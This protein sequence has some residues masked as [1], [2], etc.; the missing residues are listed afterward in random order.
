MNKIG[1]RVLSLFMSAIMLLSLLPASALAAQADDRGERLDTAGIYDWL[2]ENY[3][4]AEE[5]GSI[6]Y[7]AGALAYLLDMMPD[8]PGN[9]GRSIAAFT[10][11]DEERDAEAFR[12]DAEELEAAAYAAEPLLALYADGS[13]YLVA[14]TAEDDAFFDEELPAEEPTEESSE[15]PTEE[16]FEEPA[17]EPSEEP[18]E[19]PTEEPFEEPSEGDWESDLL[20]NAA[21]Q[22]PV[23]L[24]ALYKGG[25]SGNLGGQEGGIGTLDLFDD[26]TVTFVFLDAEGNPIAIES[27][28][29]TVQDAEYILKAGET[30]SYPAAPV[31][32]T[33]AEGHH[34]FT[35]W[36]VN[37]ADFPEDNR[38]TTAFAKAHDGE[39]I[40]VTPEYHSYWLVSFK[41]YETEEICYTAEVPVNGTLTSAQ[42]AEAD[43]AFAKTRPGWKPVW[44]DSFDPK[45]PVT[46]DLTVIAENSIEGVWVSFDS[47]DGTFV[48]QKQPD[49][50]GTLDLTGSETRPT[51]KGYTFAGWYRDEAAETDPVGDTLTGVTTSVT[52]YAK[53]TPVETTYTVIYWMENANWDNATESKRD[54]QQ[55]SSFG[56]E[57]REGLTGQPATYDTRNL[58]NGGLGDQDGA[59]FTTNPRVEGGK[60][61]SGDGTTIVNVFYDRLS[62]SMY[63]HGS[64]SNGTLTCGQEEHT[65]TY[66]RRTGEWWYGYTYYGGCY[67]RTGG[68]SPMCGQ[69]EHTH[70][71]NCYAAHVLTAKYGA[72]I[73]EQWPKNSFGTTQW[74]NADNSYSSTSRTFM[75]VMPL[76][77]QFDGDDGH[78]YEPSRGSRTQTR[79]FYVEALPGDSVD[80]TDQDGVKY[81]EYRRVETYSNFGSIATWV[82]LEGCDFKT[83]DTGSWSSHNH[84]VRGYYLRK[85]F[86]VQ[87]QMPGY[88]EQNSTVSVK[89]GAPI[90]GPE[91]YTPELA[92]KTFD[93]WYLSEAFKTSAADTLNGHMPSKSITV[94]GRWKTETCDVTVRE[95]DK[96]DQF[97]VTVNSKT[98]MTMEQLIAA[99]KAANPGFDTENI[100]AFYEGNALVNFPTTFD[101]NV[102]LTVGRK[103]QTKPLSY[104]EN[105]GAATPDT[106][107]KYPL[108][109][110]AP[111]R[112]PAQATNDAG[113][114]FDYWTSNLSG[115]TTKY[116]P[117][118]MILVTPNTVLTAHYA[119]V[120]VSMVKVTYHPNFTGTG[121]A[122]ITS[123]LVVNNKK[124]TIP[125]APKGWV[126]AQTASGYAFKGWATS[127]T[128]AAADPNYAP[129][130]L[131]GVDD[132]TAIPNELWAVWSPIEYTITYNLVGGARETGVTYVEKYTV[133]TPSFTGNYS[134]VKEHF[135]FTGWTTPADQ[136]NVVYT[137]PTKSIE[138]PQGTTGNLTF[139]ANWETTKYPYTVEYYY[140][141]NGNS[142]SATKFGAPTGAPTGDPVGLPYGTTG[143]TA[144]IA[145]PYN[146]VLIGD[147]HYAYDSATT[148]T[149]SDVAESNVVRVYYA[150]DEKGGTPENPGDGIPDKY[151]ITVNYVA[152]DNGTIVGGNKTETITITS[153]TSTHP[154][155]WATSGNVTT[156][157]RAQAQA[158]STFKFTNWTVPA[159][160][161]LAGSVST[162]NPIPETRLT[163]VTGD[164]TYIFTANFE[165][166][167]YT[168]IYEANQGTW[169][170]GTKLVGGNY[171]ETVNAG[172]NVVTGTATGAISR[173]GFDLVGWTYTVNGKEVVYTSNTKTP[174]RIATETGNTTSNTITLTA[175]WV[176]QTPS[177]TII[178]HFR[179][180]KLGEVGTTSTATNNDTFVYGTPLAQ[181]I[182]NADKADQTYPAADGKTYIYDSTADAYRIGTTGNILALTNQTLTADGTEIHLYY[183]VDA[184]E[185]PAK[186][187]PDPEKPGDGEPDKN[188]VRVLFESAGNGTVTGGGA[189]QI[190]TRANGVTPVEDEIT[191]TPATGFAF[192][193]WTKDNGTEAVNPFTAQ[194]GVN[195]GDTI[196]FK[197]HFEKDEIGTTDPTQPDGVPDKY[198]IT[199]LYQSADTSKGVVQLPK[200]AHSAEVITI[201]SDGK[202]AETGVVTSKAHA[203]AVALDGYQFAKWTAPE[204]IYTGWNAGEYAN[205]TT[206]DVLMMGVEGGKTYTFTAYFKDAA[207]TLVYALNGGTWMDGSKEDRTLSPLGGKTPVFPYDDLAREGYV[208]SGWALSNGQ[209]LSS[210]KTIETLAKELQVLDNTVTLTAVW[211]PA[212]EIYQHFNGLT[213]TDDTVK[214]D[215]DANGNPLTAEPG[216]LVS[217]LIEAYARDYTATE[218]K[219][220]KVYLYDA[221]RTT[222]ALNVAVGDGSAKLR[223]DLYYNVDSWSEPDNSDATPDGKPDNQQ[224]LVKFESADAVMGTVDGTTT[225]VFGA[226]DF[227][228]EEVS[229]KAN[230]GYAFDIWVK[231]SAASTEAVN[232]FTERT[233]DGGTIITFYARFAEDKIGGTD[234]AHPG[235][236]IPDKYQ[237]TVTYKVV[238][239]VWA[240]KTTA[241]KTAAVTLA[242]KDANG[243]WTDKAPAAADRQ[244]PDNMIANDGYMTP[245]PREAG[246]DKNPTSEELSSNPKDNVFTYTF[247]TASFPYTIEYWYDGVQDTDETVYGLNTT[248][249]E[250]VTLS[251]G[252]AA[253][254]TDHNGTHYTL[255]STN[256]SLVITSDVSKNVIKV[257]YAKD[258]IG[259]DPEHPDQPDGTPDKYQA[260][261]VYQV[262]AGGTLVLDT[263]KTSGP[264]TRVVTITNQWGDPVEDGDVDLADYIG[265]PDVTNRFVNWTVETTEETWAFGTV[266]TREA[267]LEDIKLPVKGEE[268]YTLTAN[269]TANTYTVVFNANGGSWTNAMSTDDGFVMASDYTRQSVKRTST[270]IVNIPSQ[271]PVRAGHDFIGW[272]VTYNAANGGEIVELPTNSV[273]AGKLWTATHVDDSLTITVT[274]AWREVPVTYTVVQHFLNAEGK[275]TGKIDNQM[276]REALRDTAIKDLEFVAPL[277]ADTTFNGVK[278]AYDHHTPTGTLTGNQTVVDIYYD[279]DSWSEPDSETGGDGE[280]DKNQVLVKFV[281]ELE[282]KGQVGG[283]TVQVF[284]LGDAASVTLDRSVQAAGVNG[285]AFDYWT[286]DG[287]TEKLREIPA[288]L[289]AV[290]GHTYVFTAHFD[291]DEIGTKNPTQPDGVPDKYQAAIVYA[292]GPNGTLRN[293]GENPNEILEWPVVITITDSEGNFA[294]SGTVKLTQDVRTVA[295]EGY[296]FDVWTNPDGKNILVLPTELAVEGDKTYTFT[297]NF[298]EDTKKPG[299]DGKE[300]KGSDGTPD[301]Y[302][303]TVVYKVEH[304][305]W[306]EGGKDEKEYF[307]TL[308]V[309]DKESNSWKAVNPDRRVPT[310]M[311]ADPTFKDNAQSSWTPSNPGEATLSPNKRNEFT[312]AFVPQGAI[313]VT[314]QYLDEDNRAI[315]SNTEQIVYENDALP[316]VSAPAISGYARIGAASQTVTE[317]MTQTITFRYG[318]DN[319]NQPGNS[320]TGGDGIPDSRQA[321]VR[322]SSSNTSYGTVNSSYQVYTLTE[323]Q[324]DGTYRGTAALRNT[325]ATTT[326]SRTYFNSWLYGNTVLS[327]GTALAAELSVI[328][329]STYSVTASFGREAGGGGGGG[330]GGTGGGGGGGTGGTTI[331][332]A[333]V[334]LAGDLQL[335]R[336]DHFAY[337]KGYQDGT[338]RPNNPL[339]RAQVATIFYRL[340]DETS[341]TIFFQETNDFTDV[342]DDFWACKA[343]STLTNAGIITGFKDGT[344]RPNAY[345]TRAQFAA[346]AARFDNVVP[347]LE[348]PFSDVA[349]DYWAR[350]LI[351]YAASKGWINGSNGKFRPLENI[352]RVEAMDFINNVLERHVDAEG[353]LEG[354]TT[355]SDVKPS[356][357]YY[358]VVLEATNSHD[359]ERRKEGELMENWTA[360]NE[361]PVWDE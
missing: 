161:G 62:Y 143:V 127:A 322:Y 38:L 256:H 271:N 268:T 347:G 22:I 166:D 103:D 59:G 216:T 359:H 301:K 282:E 248:L 252:L 33:D 281:S 263:E 304:G 260:T 331:N 300:E 148:I 314:V 226:T 297:A 310:G 249:G 189:T 74:L 294:E 28:D 313:I 250:T 202:R 339:T 303:T 205:A 200:D 13:A 44:E 198:Q 61:I 356:D 63:F 145:A 296:A 139:V 81:T 82:D 58:P 117:G 245:V 221:T 181:L 150:L 258:E 120:T 264:V 72:D 87:F 190:F 269:F 172:A 154:Q 43:T 65:H 338:V 97:S 259:T 206:Q 32:E 244:I 53:W 179:N 253:P 83:G 237:T 8:A 298:A 342:K 48:G 34:A 187:D 23:T 289:P 280:S 272:M 320:L 273:Q 208:F 329:G 15:E 348:N 90:G 104:I 92:G 86:N 290:K 243:V 121:I 128:A 6:V 174:V 158:N 68:S 195:G 234:P 126:D 177:Y 144:S 5:D 211:K 99:I 193:I 334:P 326:L 277:L 80:A 35:G 132:G 114:T 135:D 130:K 106:A 142:G 324:A 345:I 70:S 229:P 113:E 109:T 330:G 311:Q 257:E 308:Y 218:T 49:D 274:A 16:P 293:G 233:A 238:N 36:T 138:V 178:R 131:I 262:T 124:V 157:V 137:T 101:H 152:G 118:Q 220:G 266:L 351:A 10:I 105:G 228:P 309:K 278:Y 47:K 201:M 160:A 162:S 212:Y 55:Y 141:N 45:A 254:E 93:Q 57:T 288:A 54:P 66:D 133:E 182:T 89:Y 196:T 164:S 119:K 122:D 156:T 183:D 232:P 340:L 352:T 240:D 125:G 107:K 94:Y 24:W 14:E 17:E 350:D 341:R 275:E 26:E 37:A 349:E 261:I 7:P 230:E 42:L 168:V 129:G 346:I 31:W 88:P 328:G 325:A 79:I 69:T 207:Y 353:L 140:Y 219:T 30:L 19:E 116:Y 84:V 255:E 204:S 360:L 358:Y 191:L 29:G 279:A 251:K 112:A 21:R 236:G 344:F 176:E 224:I 184:W 223:I 305:T 155:K 312:Y 302:Q 64:S 78:Y 77:G 173:T 194:T 4:D 284:T 40:Q 291:K 285:Y 9:D 95:M 186:Q 134:P 327:R 46:Q 73:S 96:T 169:A 111:V 217:T 225:Q 343:I 98:V 361:D 317:R 239:G 85:N 115:D 171:Q 2:L 170:A 355:W 192:D 50:N 336:D 1:K 188:Q 241:D 235:D 247:K 123:D 146:K 333:E 149:I 265:T 286:L 197:A 51:R 136:T 20:L 163:N 246:W 147:K 108:N 227:K 203:T 185:D 213:V 41:G 292:A 159:Q 222:P 357:S 231:D 335:N 318:V 76:N 316:T 299:E 214:I 321:L 307:L 75:E 295:D 12:L 110:M 287:S 165:R 332:D 215:R 151:Q 56:S 175:K 180:E 242:E 354:C 283:S 199:V 153:E 209:K 323:Q 3:T 100:L 210:I 102:T 25:E 67:P 18:F 270:Q 91:I 315:R 52:L 319:W 11:W 276:E 306:A 71:S 337:I 167:T 60:A 267:G 27:T 39:T